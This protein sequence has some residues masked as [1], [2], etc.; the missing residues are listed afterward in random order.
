MPRDSANCFFLGGQ[1]VCNLYLLQINMLLKI[2]VGEI[3]RFS[4]PGQC[5][6]HVCNTAVVSLQETR[7]IL[8]PKACTCPDS[9]LL[10]TDQVPLNGVAAFVRHVSPASRRSP[11]ESASQWHSIETCGI[12]ITN[13]YHPPHAPFTVNALPMPSECGTAIVAGD[14]HCH[15]TA[16]DYYSAGDAN[17]EALKKIVQ[18]AIIIP[19]ENISW[20]K[21]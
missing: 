21:P 4:G 15:R 8:V 7:T 17:V 10:Q 14:F 19:P 6:G 3:T 1:N 2:S 12:F 16:W 9:I 11:R 5:P 20:L 18:R 13:V